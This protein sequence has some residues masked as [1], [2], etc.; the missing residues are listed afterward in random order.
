LD[1]G[2]HLIMPLRDRIGHK[3]SLTGRTLK[4]ETALGD[5]TQTRLHGTIYWQVLDPQ[6]ADAVIDQAEHLIR[7]GALGAVQPRP[8]AGG[9]TH[10]KRL[11]QQLNATLRPQGMLVTRVDLAPA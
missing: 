9:T 5:A 10:N 7:Q 1:A 6:T 11:K 8:A 4:L 2:T 3:I